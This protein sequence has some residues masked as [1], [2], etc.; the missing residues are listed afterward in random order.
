VFK[1][2][3][4]LYTVAYFLYHKVLRQLVYRSAFYMD[5]ITWRKKQVCR[6]VGWC[7]TAVSPDL[8]MVG[9][10]GVGECRGRRDN[11]P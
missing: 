5:V 2:I 10:F 9:Q 8:G 1:V 7:L 3:V 4:P 6:L 11:K